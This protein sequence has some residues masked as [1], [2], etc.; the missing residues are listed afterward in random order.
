MASRNV[1]P[2]ARF[3]VVLIACGL[4][5]WSEWKLQIRQGWVQLLSRV[6]GR[7]PEA[8][9]AQRYCVWK[10]HMIPNLPNPLLGPWP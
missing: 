9:P 6:R 10:Q 4:Q 7:G 3:Q 8:E 5:P 1:A 2:E